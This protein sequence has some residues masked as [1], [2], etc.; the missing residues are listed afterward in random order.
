MNEPSLPT[1]SKGHASPSWTREPDPPSTLEKNWLFELRKERFRSRQSGKVHEYFVVDLADAVHVIALTPDNQIVL[2]EQFR[3]G[4]GG[5]SLEPPGGLIDPGE[6][7]LEAG[8]RELLEETGYK[9]DFPVLL[10]TVWSCPSILTSRISTVLIT[11]AEQVSTPTP[12]EGEE[13]RIK[14]VP[15]RE[16]PHLIRS[17]QISHALTV[18]GLLWWLVAEFPDTPFEL[19]E[20]FRPGSRQFGLRS[21]MIAVMVFGV[22]FAMIRAIRNAGEPLD[23]V[24]TY[25]LMFPL[26]V[27]FVYRQL[28]IVPSTTLTRLKPQLSKLVIIK[29]FA[30]LGVT[31]VLWLL[32]VIL[33]QF[34]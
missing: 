20:V 18:Q 21:L 19:P 34:F 27:F 22:I 25:L 12:D 4:S 28:E 29:L 6:D 32:V 14:Q 30:A 23:A 16:I 2:V 15:S 5:D 13:L 7:P 17:G 33:F 26:A 10:S 31:Q 9:G 11:N 3:C 8:A 1:F 24:L